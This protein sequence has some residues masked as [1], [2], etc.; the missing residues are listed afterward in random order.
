MTFSANDIRTQRFRR[1][2]RGYDPEEVHLYLNLLAEEIERL[3]SS[4]RRLEHEKKRLEEQLE[5]LLDKERHIRNTLVAVQQTRDRIEEEAHRE[6][7]LIIREAELQRDRILESARKELEK[8]YLD[9]EQLNME[10]HRLQDLILV[11]ANALVRWV[12]QRREEETKERPARV[13]L[14]SKTNVQE[15]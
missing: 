13:S 4:I 12:K 15:K 3:V 7:E 8:I 10:R 5:E 6:A 1:R 11:E 14:L 9:I 2:L